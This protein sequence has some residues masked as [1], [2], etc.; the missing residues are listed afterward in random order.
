ME[1][2]S[3]SI[4]LD[5]VKFLI[6]PITK[7]LQWFY[8]KLPF[9]L[10]RR[11]PSP[12]LGLIED[13]MR[14]HTWEYAKRGDEEIVV[15]NTC[16]KITN[17]LPYH[18]TALNAYLKRPEEI[19]GSVMIHEVNSQYWGTYPIPKG[20]TTDMSINFVINK[21]HIQSPK[22]IIIAAIELQDAIGR[23]HKF[24]DIKI[25]PIMRIEKK[26][27]NLKTEDPTKL[28]TEAE[29][30]VVAVLKNEVQQYKVRGRREGRLG[31]VEWP[32]GTMEWRAQDAKILFLN[33]KSDSTIVYSDHVNALSRLYE[34]SSKS[35][36]RIVLRTL[37]DR[38]DKKSEYRDIGYLIIFSLFE[39][40]NLQDGLSSALKKL[41]GDGANGFSDVM[42]LLD[43]LLTFRYAEFDEKTLDAIEQFVYSTK[44]HPFQIKERINAIR[45]LRMVR[46]GK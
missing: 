25:L 30:Q 42:R 14:G 44:E 27:E 45:V 36:Q 19:K 7:I 24:S 32:R 2:L 8:S 12:K 37:L 3:L 22:Q 34:S 15:L 33:E 41:E 38:I 13:Q 26:A 9:E 4:I 39:F 21:K 20:Y 11:K 1:G 5:I 6:S 29:K 46:K 40:G 35:S 10:K 28:K 43:I 17:T 31:T 16:W 18:I 23:T